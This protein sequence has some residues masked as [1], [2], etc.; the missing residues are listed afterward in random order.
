M[1]SKMY[2]EEKGESFTINEVYLFHPCLYYSKNRALSLGIWTDNV[3]FW[4]YTRGF[5]FSPC[6]HYVL[7]ITPQVRALR[8]T[9]S[10]SGLLSYPAHLQILHLRSWLLEEVGGEKSALQNIIFIF[11]SSPLPMG[12]RTVGLKRTTK[13]NLYELDNESL[14]YPLKSALVQSLGKDI[15]KVFSVPSGRFMSR[16]TCLY[17][18]KSTEKAGAIFQK[19]MT[20]L[21]KLCKLLS[22]CQAVHLLNNNYKRDLGDMSML[23]M[24]HMPISP[25]FGAQIGEKRR[26]CIIKSP[27][28]DNDWH[29]FWFLSFYAWWQ[30]LCS[31]AAKHFQFKPQLLSYT[32]NIISKIRQQLHL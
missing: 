9:S 23:N 17:L 4:F 7:E 27:A 31:S 22:L 2:G 13:I 18:V 14:I 3:P 12:G 1:E 19:L 30:L 6:E 26:G 28:C 10:G 32:P 15:N 11:G 24:K 16:L 5:F 29:N 20:A 25:V 21:H 8:D